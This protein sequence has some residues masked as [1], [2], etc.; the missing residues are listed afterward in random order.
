MNVQPAVVFDK[1]TLP[2]LVHVLIDPRSSGADHL[3]QNFLTDLRNYRLGRP[4]LAKAGQQ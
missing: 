2:E 4:F 3:R 1:S